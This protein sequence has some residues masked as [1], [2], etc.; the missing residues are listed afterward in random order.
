MNAHV[1]R[2]CTHRVDPAFA[3]LAGRCFNWD[4]LEQHPWPA[5][6]LWPDGT[7][8]Y[9]NPAWSVFA[10]ANGGGSAV[11]SHWSL[12]ANYF[13]AIT[14]SLRPFF[15]DLLKNA[16]TTQQSLAPYTHEYECSSADDF[17]RFAL[18]IFALPD[19]RG[20]MLVHSL[21]VA[22]PHSI[23]TH[24]IAAPD[25]QHY[26]TEDGVIKQCA[27]CRRVE[28]RSRVGHWDWVPAWIK[29]PPACISHT[30]CALCDA[31]YYSHL[32]SRRRD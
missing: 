17:R 5:A 15:A 21:L 6:G 18:Q 10:H 11:D 24:P 13:A 28:R 20:Y 19:K 29:H 26:E 14:D 32:A 22:A 8:A 2:D 12:G 30:I 4:D 1:D 3:D 9:V 7:I 27:H 31:F 23:T 16:P 25:L